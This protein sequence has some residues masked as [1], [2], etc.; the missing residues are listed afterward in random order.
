MTV[1][2]IFK[3]IIIIGAGGHAKVLIDA[4]K[5]LGAPVLGISESE[6]AR[7]NTELLGIPIICDDPG[8]KQ[9]PAE[10]VV[11]VNGIGGVK[12]TTL[13]TEVFTRFK[14]W[15]Y[16]FSRVIHSAAVI[17]AD[18]LLDEG[19]QVMAGAILQAGV[20]VGENSIINTKTSVDHD[21]QIGRHVHLAPGVTLCGNVQIG[22][23]VHVG[24]GAT[25][26]QGINVGPRSVIGAGT[27]V[28][29]NV[30]SGVTIIGVPGRII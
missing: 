11:L 4:L 27:L 25:I 30:P 20:R 26:I 14:M 22:D 23:S 1:A 7:R 3:P 10:S 12:D 2:E 13:R 28:Q 18:T 5:L 6:P 29:K 21:C 24:S 19:V 8:V 16:V 15:G 17:S 9:Y